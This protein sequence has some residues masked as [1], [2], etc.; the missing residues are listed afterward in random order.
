MT[1]V[2]TV[3][4][5]SLQFTLVPSDSEKYISEDK[6]VL[7]ERNYSAPDSAIQVH[8]FGDRVNKQYSA[9]QSMRNSRST[10]ALKYVGQTKKTKG[11]VTEI[12]SRCEREDGQFA[13]HH[14]L[15]KC[16]DRFLECYTVYGNDS[17][18]EITLEMLSSCP[19]FRSARS[20]RSAWIMF[21]IPSIFTACA[22]SGA[23]KRNWKKCPPQIS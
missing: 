12:V 6:L 2:Y 21:P 9:G 11:K 23:R 19:P 18:R 22:A 16:G 14:L 7:K 13:E 8:V 15:R 1:A 4:D 5:G 20:R 17:D 10:F 3:M